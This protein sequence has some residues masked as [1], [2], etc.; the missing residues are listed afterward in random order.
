MGHLMHDRLPNWVIDLVRAI[1]TYEEE[2][3]DPTAA[4]HLKRECYWNQPDAP[5][6][7]G[8][9]RD[10]CLGSLLNFI[11]KEVRDEA[12][13]ISEYLHQAAQAAGPGVVG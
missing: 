10:A 7:R 3:H 4:C 5:S 12:E 11:P 9:I 8:M 13:R 6:T 1:Q 2:G